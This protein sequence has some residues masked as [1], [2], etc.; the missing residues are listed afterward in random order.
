MNCD[1]QHQI[2]MDQ[3]EKLR[4]SLDTLVNTDPRN[5]IQHFFLQAL[6]SEFAHELETNKSIIKNILCQAVQQSQDVDGTPRQRSAAILKGVIQTNLL[7]YIRLADLRNKAVFEVYRVCGITVDTYFERYSS[8]PGTEEQNACYGHIAH[9]SAQAT[10]IQTDE[11]SNALMWMQILKRYF[12]VH[13]ALQSQTEL[14]RYNLNWIG[15][16][17]KCHIEDRSLGD[18]IWE[19]FLD[20]WALEN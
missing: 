18:L 8:P 10:A 19:L 1:A 7:P 12:V 13:D 4:A 11:L 20:I 6:H 3:V 9:G 2:W 16:M 5:I 15:A 14:N 17:W